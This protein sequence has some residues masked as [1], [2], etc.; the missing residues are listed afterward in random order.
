MAL[1]VDPDLLTD[2]ALDDGST[3]VFIDTSA[4]TIKLVPGQGTLI[5]QDG[6]T[7]KAVYSF[8]KE[9]WKNDPLTKNLAA[10]DFPMVPITD[11]FYELVEGWDWADATTEQTIRSGG[12]LVRDTSGNLI[13]QYANITALGNI[14]A[15]DQLY[16][17]LGVGAVAFTFP[18]AVNEAVQIIDD[19]NGD[20][21]Y[22]DGYDRSGTFAIYNREQAQLF[23]SSDLAA[24]GSSDLLAPKRFSFPVGTGADLNISTA[25]TGIDSNTDGTADV[26]VFAG[27]SITFYSTPQSRNIGGTNR[28]FGIIID[29]NNGTKQE[30]YEFVQ[31]SLRQANDQD[32]G[33]GTLIGNV[34]PE[35]LEFVGSTL[36]TKAASSNYQ[37]GGT[38]VYIDNFNTVDTNDL[39]FVDN[40]DTERTFPFVAAGT[41][42][43]NAN[44]VNDPD[45]VYFVYFTDGVDAGDEFGNSGA[46]LVDD[47]S[48]SDLSGSVTGASI[49]FTFDYD[50]NNQGNRT[51][52][53]DAN[54]TAV[55]IGLNTGQYVKTTATITRSNA[56]SINFVAAQER[57]YSNPA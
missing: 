14:E 40:T 55:A 9:E 38:G 49:A 6:V 41:L 27:M 51:P 45:A 56:N 31:W 2:S 19:P 50:G 33:A 52:A 39:V 36:K 21:N 43:F 13:K 22:V 5:A 44:L 57:N 34:M 29:G 25:D 7:E 4:Q 15:D 17:D 3:N 48:G 30:I 32:A 37:G 42:N 10:F 54:V 1:I 53:T 28:D 46:I 26:G 23:S 18:G 12:W 11:E 47:N 35:L 20:G 24:I 16:Y 8:L